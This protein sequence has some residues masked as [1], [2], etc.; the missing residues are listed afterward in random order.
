M[1]AHALE[2]EKAN[3]YKEGRSYSA[4][5]SF[6]RFAIWAY[7]RNC[8]VSVHDNVETHSPMLVAGNYLN[9]VLD[10]AVL[11]VTIPHNRQLHFWALA[12]FFKIPIIG[13][14]FAA[15]GVLPVDTKT[16]SNAK[17]FE[18]TVDC[19]GQNQAVAVFPEGTSY[20]APHHLPFK[21]GLSWA[22]YEF[23]AQQH[24]RRQRGEP[25][26]HSSITILPVGITYTTK[27]KWR[28]DVI[29]HYSE[30]IQVGEED[31]VRFAED[32][33][34]TVKQLTTQITESIESAT[35]N[36]PDW[37]TDNA[38]ATARSI[39]FGHRNGIQLNS[40]VKISQS[41]INV[42]HPLMIPKLTEL[43]NLKA[44]LLSF[45][46]TTKLL[47]LSDQD[48]AVYQ[49]QKI[50]ITAATLRLL[51]ISLKLLIELP[52]F[53]PGIIIHSPVY[54][55]GKAAESVEKFTES[56]AQDK[57]AL[58]LGLLV[59]LY[60]TLFYQIWRWTRFS[61]GGFLLGAFLI[62]TFVRY[63]MAMLDKRYDLLKELV[64]A[65]RIFVALTGGKS[66]RAEVEEA[67]ELRKWCAANL[68]KILLGLKDQGSEDA[69]Y[70]VD[71]AQAFFQD[72]VAP[73]MD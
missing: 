15:V 51:R 10:P 65:W 55:L 13:R 20:T 41:L 38:M 34:A 63:H 33:K 47:Q 70:L 59:P 64:A 31:R 53:L 57:I 71:Q 4:V 16:R 32:P 27:D 37:D 67:V 43:A 12:R 9:M 2:N 7:F 52:L 22:A 39:L 35:I 49:K 61:F 40:Y 46:R 50:T 56:I 48:I 28:S 60:S 25:A 26:P 14:I 8:H 45:S 42:L 44:R 72:G 54:L 21:D 36:A 1:S 62:P 11:I 68:K 23:L 73:A 3:V 29:V 18:S 19:L 30:T 58:A 66:Q 24:Q 5:R 69:A 6:C 17:L